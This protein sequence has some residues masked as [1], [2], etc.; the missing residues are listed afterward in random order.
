MPY[1][2]TWEENGIYREYNGTVSSED[3]INSNNEFYDDMMSDNSLYQIIDFSKIDKIDADHET[4]KYAIA[5]SCGHSLTNKNIKIACVI[6]RSEIIL[7]IAACIKE[8]IKIQPNW[9]FRVFEDVGSARQWITE[10]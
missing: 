3:V 7:S 1:K 9:S 8:L 6:R 10:N 5:M 2:L 4:I